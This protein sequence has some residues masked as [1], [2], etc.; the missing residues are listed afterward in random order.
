MRPAASARERSAALASSHS[1]PRSALAAPTGHRFRD[2]ERLRRISAGEA[3]VAEAGANVASPTSSVTVQGGRSPAIV[4]T[5]ACMSFAIAMGA[6]FV[7][8]LLADL[9][10]D[11]FAVPEWGAAG[12][13]VAFVAL[14]IRNWWVARRRVTFSATGLTFGGRSYVWSE[15]DHVAIVR[16]WYVAVVE[17]PL[18]VRPRLPGR[19]RA[20]Y[21]GYPM[22]GVH[23]L[24]ASWFDVL[25]LL[26][27]FEPI[28]G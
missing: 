26:E 21:R 10:T 8:A 4:F 12:F 16:A 28:R 14:L 7:A 1:K 6:F 11:G 19:Y 3:S 13:I 27:R 20:R 24:R 2:V 17:D 15:F 22:A 5:D 18:G 25:M 9:A 23:H